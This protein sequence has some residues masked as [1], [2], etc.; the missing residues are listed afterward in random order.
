MGGSAGLGSLDLDR[1]TL[2]SGLGL[3]LCV[4]DTIIAGRPSLDGVGSTAFDLVDERFPVEAKRVDLT[5]LSFVVGPYF[6]A[7]AFFAAGDSSRTVSLLG[8][9]E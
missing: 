3:R 7:A 8:N 4:R 9:V 5:L 2:D 6:G 1:E